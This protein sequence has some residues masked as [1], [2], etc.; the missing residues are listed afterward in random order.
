M[1]IGLDIAKRMGA[2]VLCGNEI[3]TRVFCG[4]PGQ[5]LR[6]LEF[7]FGDLT[8]SMFYV[9]KLNSFVNANTTRALLLRT[10]YLTNSLM[11]MWL[12]NIEFVIA[13]QA[14][15]FQGVKTKKETQ[16]LFPGLSSDE[17]DAVVVLL[18]GLKRKHTD[19]TIRSMEG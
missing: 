6:G 17:A 12:A 4:T 3:H 9:E 15:K 18:Y 19:F 2:A 5:Q 13:T 11:E 1:K 14:R 10:G 8:G 16:G 7:A